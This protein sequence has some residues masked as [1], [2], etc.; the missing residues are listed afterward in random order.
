MIIACKRN[1]RPALADKERELYIISQ[2]SL[3]T[4]IDAV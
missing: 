1:Y 2:A 3:E 4:N